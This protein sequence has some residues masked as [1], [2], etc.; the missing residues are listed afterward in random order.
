MVLFS[1]S[2]WVG[3]STF[4]LPAQERN[5]ATPSCN[6]A[7]NAEAGIQVVEKT[8][9]AKP[10]VKKKIFPWLGVIL[11][12]AVAGGL[13]YYFL[14]LKTTLHVDTDP[15]GATVY[16]D[17]KATNKVTPCELKTSIGSHKIKVSLEGYADVERDI[18]VKNG[19]NA[20]MIPLD[21]GVYTLFTP[22]GNA[23]VQR[24]A[25]CLISW[26]SNA[27]AA[28]AAAPAS[29]RPLAVPKVDLELFQGETKVADIAHGVPNS[30]S[31]TWNIP[32]STAEGHDFKI[33]ISCPGV[34]ESPAFGPAFNLLGF[35]EDFSD[36]VADFWLADDGASWKAAGG[37]F[38]A[39]HAGAGVAASIYDFFYA[40]SSF[41]V[42]SKMRWSEF[43]GS[44][45]GSPLFIM[46]GTTNSFSNNSGYVLGYAADGT[47]SIYQLDGY[48]FS[49]PPAAAPTTI[50][51]AG[52]SAVNKGLNSWN[53][54]RVVRD[55]SSYALFINDIL[56]HTFSHSVYNPNYV[57]LGF[58]SAGSRTSCDF[59]YV[60]MTVKP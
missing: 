48:N 11:S 26:D 42:E 40:E 19:K 59:D 36:S 54:V 16:L 14:I 45:G 18:V 35:K 13:I 20:L 39:S 9:G 53:T 58:G 27:L 56:V 24:E 44:A 30:G 37:Y 41:S 8:E 21:L 38:T 47:V 32:G 31:F 5:T 3:V 52:S 17:G 22:A 60:Y 57:L 4:S 46:L 51:S 1:F 10:Q 43:D 55:G 6:R 49:E 28:A 12:L 7:E 25:P 29:L 50:Y 33:R 23:N 15:A 2:V 34:A